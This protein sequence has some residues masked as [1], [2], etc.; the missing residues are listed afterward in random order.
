MDHQE[1]TYGF[2]RTFANTTVPAVTEAVT[3]A[4]KTEG[5]GVLTRIDVHET[6][7]KKINVDFDE[8]VILGACN[9]AMAH[10]ALQVDRELGLL[11][12]CNVVVRATGPS[13][14]HVSVIDPNAMFTVTQNAELE[15]IATEVAT[16]L[17]RALAV[18]SVN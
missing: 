2:S 6:L 4:L 16:R 11:L 17:K 18:I 1:S 15:P 3:A 7:K 8:Y 13:E 5:F 14:V 10:S 12:P 9:P